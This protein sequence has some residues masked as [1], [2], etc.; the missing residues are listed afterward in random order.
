MSTSYSRPLLS[1]TLALTLVALV[2][3]LLTVIA[4]N[5]ADPQELAEVFALP[6]G[7]QN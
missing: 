7:N 3:L 6:P 4:I 5:H 2:A 1:L